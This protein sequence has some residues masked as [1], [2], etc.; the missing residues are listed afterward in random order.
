MQ[1]L[2]C[3]VCSSP[4]IMGKRF[5]SSKCKATYASH[6]RPKIGNVTIGRKFCKIAFG[7][8]IH[9]GKTFLLKSTEHPRLL[10]RI[11]CSK[12][13][14]HNHGCPKRRLPLR[15]CE[16]CGKLFKPK[17][18]SKCNPQRF[19]CQSCGTKHKNLIYGN[20]TDKQETRDK[21]SAT[22]K[23]NWRNLP[24]ETKN[25]ILAAGK[26]PSGNRS[27]QWLGKWIQ[28]PENKERMSNYWKQRL[29]DHPEDCVMMR[30]RR[31]YKTQLEKAVE[32]VLTMFGLNFKY[33]KILYLKDGFCF[34]DFAVLD[35]NILIECNGDYWHT[36]K[37]IAEREKRFIENGY[38][39]I[40]LSEK[41]IKAGTRSIVEVLL[42]S[43]LKEKMNMVA[44]KF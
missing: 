36:S 17:N 43:P 5:C 24:E 41:C 10:R 22:S 29:K 1:S 27:P 21:I 37:Q 18:R 40:M 14:R 25:K 33:N 9:C 12:K 30:L 19:C 26:K 4:V 38:F 28:K 34:P 15:K 2:I 8:C 16:T 23:K 35:T 6:S 20:P 32:S 13:C 42:S 3:E 39:S 11:F 44:I 31:N 7:N